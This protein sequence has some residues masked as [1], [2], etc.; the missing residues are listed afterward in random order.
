MTFDDSYF[1]GAGYA[2]SDQISWQIPNQYGYASVVLAAGQGTEVTLNNPTVLSDQRSYAN[3]VFAAGMAKVTVN[4]G[5]ITTNNSLGNGHGVDVTYMG[6]VYLKDTVVHTSG[7]TS[8][9]LASDFGGGFIQGERLDVTT[10]AGSSPAI[11]CAGT[12]IIMAKDSKLTANGA[13]GIILAHD[14][15]VVALDNCEVTGQGDAVSGLQALPSPE[16]SAGC[17]FFDFGSKLT[18]RTGAV[19]GQS[20][21]RTVMNLIGTQCQSDA[22]KAISVTNGILTVNLWDTELSGSIE[23]AEGCTLVVNVYEG[24]KLTGDVT[25][26]VEINVYAGGEYSGSH[27]ANALSDSGEPAPAMGGFDDYLVEYWGIGAMNWTESTAKTFADTYEPEVIENSAASFAVEGC[28]AVAYNPDTYDP[29][30]NGVDLGKLNVGG[31]HGFTEDEVFGGAES[32]TN[33]LDEQNG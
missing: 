14:H 27:G 17:T 22:G 2:D 1:Y 13:T 32:R 29:S 33:P 8:G 7:D 19:L 3:G 6:H 20:G 25:G 18:S 28:A 10:E 23:C 9:G 31:A 15:S 24:G 11:F 12:S 5:S 26:D 21:G 16:A 30:E 4:G